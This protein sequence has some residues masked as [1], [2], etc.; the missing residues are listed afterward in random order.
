MHCS[1]K[2]PY[3]QGMP[4]LSTFKSKFIVFSKWAGLI[5]G[6]LIGLFLLFKVVFF[7]KELVSPTPPPPPTA[8]FGK[9][10]K[11]FFPSG[12]KKNFSYT[13]DTLSGKLPQLPDRTNIYEMTKAKPD[14]LAVERASEKMATLK[15]DPSP[16][17]LSDILYRWKSLEPPIKSLVMN[18]N[19]VSF[20]LYSSYLTDRVVLSGANLPDQKEAVSQAQSFLQTL[21]LYPEDIDESKTKT[22]LFAITNGVV[23]PS[24]SLSTAKLISVD[25]FQKSIDDMQIVYPAGPSSTMNLVIAGGES[26]PQVVSARFFYQKVGNKSATYLI[27]SAQQAF[28]ELKSGKAYVS[29]HQGKNLN[30]VIKNVYLGFYIEGREQKYLMPVIVFEG[31]NNF[32]AYVSAV[33]D[34]WISN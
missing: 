6:A 28:E 22:K 2:L 33:K 27:K 14:L 16:E 1:Q 34:E 32:V 9:L 8:S 5:L 12:I 17:H 11:V 4:T 26:E 7:I 18:V 21:E 23:S 20:T 31:T 3:T 13:I 29:S 30:V 25:F 19:M 24:L 10:P 15:F